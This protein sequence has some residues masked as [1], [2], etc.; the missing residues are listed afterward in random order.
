MLFPLVL[1]VPKFDLRV[2]VVGVVS[3]IAAT[4]YVFFPNAICRLLFY[5]PIWWIGVYAAESLKAQGALVLRDLACPLFYTALSSIP[6]L[7]LCWHYYDSG[8]TLV[9]GVH[10]VLEVRHLLMSVILVV[11][12]FCWRGFSWFGFNYSIRFFSIVAPISYSL[13]ITHYLSIHKATY[14]NFL[15]SYIELLSYIIFTIAFCYLT[16]CRIYPWIRS[17]L[18]AK[19]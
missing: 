1:S 4:L 15:P 5:F 19:K 9:L 14:L 2:H 8:K 17:V 18:L 13:Y 12:A 10:P 16:E 7:I 11:G 6:L 3:V